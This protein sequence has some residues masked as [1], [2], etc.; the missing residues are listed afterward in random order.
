MTEISLT[1]PVLVIMAFTEDK[2]DR[3][4]VVKCH[5]IQ[6][7]DEEGIR[8]LIVDNIKLR[9]ELCAYLFDGQCLF[10][11]QMRIQACSHIRQSSFGLF[12]SAAHLCQPNLIKED[13]ISPA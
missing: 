13:Q 3:Q 4:D 7:P 11:S 12:F 6:P 8:T 9:R 1:F 5:S 10:P 2:L